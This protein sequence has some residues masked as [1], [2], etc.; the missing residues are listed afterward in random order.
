MHVYQRCSGA[1]L[2]CIIADPWRRRISSYKL[3]SRRSRRIRPERFGRGGMQ[4][5]VR[6]RQKSRAWKPEAGLAVAEIALT[7][8]SL[9]TSPFRVRRHLQV[10]GTSGVADCLTSRYALFLWT[11][12][13]AGSWI[14]PESLSW[15]KKTQ[16]LW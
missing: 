4:G 8:T 2:T 6:C 15:R 11:P 16:R 14:R 9:I 7:K 3:S 1:V 13:A 10:V 5:T 12:N